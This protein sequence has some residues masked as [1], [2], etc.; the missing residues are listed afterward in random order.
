MLRSSPRLSTRSMWKRRDFASRPARTSNCRWTRRRASTLPCKSARSSESIEVTAAAPLVKS[1]TAELGEV[2]TEKSVRELP[3]NGRNFAQLVYLAPGVTP[4]QQGE[5]LSGAS[6][7]NPA[8]GLQL[9]RAGQP[10]Q[11]QRL[12]GGRN[13][14]QRIHLQHRHR[15]ALHR[16]G[17]RIQGA[18]RHVL[19]RVRP[20]RGCGLGLHQVGQQRTARHRLRVPAQ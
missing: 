9:Q 2:I 11:Y 17:A 15:A 3:L 14:Q 16:V 19:G 18:D 20:R 13:R 8:R 7:F 4:G 6:S 1:E 10:G 12:A 5:N